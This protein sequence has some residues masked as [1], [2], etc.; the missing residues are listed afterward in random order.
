MGIDASLPEGHV[1]G[2]FLADHQRTRTFLAGFVEALEAGPTPGQV[3]ALL[4]EL[5]LTA[6]HDALEEDVLFPLLRQWG[7]RDSTNLCN[8]EHGHLRSLRGQLKTG[9]GRWAASPGGDTPVPSGLLD[10]ASAFVKRCREHL[11]SEEATVYQAAA[12][13]LDDADLWTQ[14]QRE[15]T[16]AEARRNG[17]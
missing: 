5:D 17:P 12:Q 13:L 11:D 1:L 10:Q 3:R 8:V 16:A 15:K 6:G 7:V 9:L 2:D 14:V 4:E